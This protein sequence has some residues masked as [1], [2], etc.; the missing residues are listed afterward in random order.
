MTWQAAGGRGNALLKL[1]FNSWRLQSPGKRRQSLDAAQAKGWQLWAI[2]INLR[3]GGTTHPF[4]LAATATGAGF[5]RSSGQLLNSDGR[6]VFYEAS[7]ELHQPPWRGLLPEQLID[8]LVQRGV[9][10]SSASRRGCIPMRLG[11]LSEHGLLGATSVGHS[12]RDAALL[13]QQLMAV[14]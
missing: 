14:R 12:R 11:A 7:N 1:S 9:Y 6:A 5:D 4:Q 3:K 10:F 8:A 13:M 2:E